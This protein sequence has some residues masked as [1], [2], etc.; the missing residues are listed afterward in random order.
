MFPRT[1]VLTHWAPDAR[2]AGA[3]ALRRIVS[4]L[5]QDRLIWC[6]LCPA[7]T[8]PVG[9]KCRLEPCSPRRLHWRLAGGLMETVWVQEVQA[10]GLARRLAELTADFEPELLWVLPELAAIN[11]GYNLHKVLGVPMHATVYD[12]LESARDV[13]LP[14]VYYPLYRSRVRRFFGAIRSFDT[15]SEGLREH[16]R[17]NYGVAPGVIDCVLPSSV[18]TEWMVEAPAQETEDPICSCRS[19]SG[20]D[21]AV[22]LR[23]GGGSAEHSSAATQSGMPV[24]RIAFCGAMRCSCEQWQTFV[25]EL[26]KLPY[27]FEFDAY[28]WEDSIPK[29]ELPS[30]VKVS[31]QPYLVDERDLIRRL[32]EGGYDAA[33]L[34]LWRESA[35]LLFS[36]TSLS[37]KLTTY[38]AAGLP[39]IVDGPEDSAAWELV[40]RHEAGLVLD[41]TTPPDGPC[42]CRSVSGRSANARDELMRLFSDQDYRERLAAGAGRLCREEFDLE[43][44]VGRLRA[45]LEG[46]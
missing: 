23:A 22:D 33:Y 25:D 45:L 19:V 4:R 17:A 7:T 27:R 31:I 28:A 21:S 36:R 46:A 9:V 12:A 29:A 24:R 8:K 39:V 32:Q 20:G 40:R 44:N 41:H 43:R 14:S 3:E 42:S 38:A 2:Y 16:V 6:S 18:P 30:N 13:A 37:S 34:P 35:R 11:V 5:P 10:R 26:G 15:I 1:L